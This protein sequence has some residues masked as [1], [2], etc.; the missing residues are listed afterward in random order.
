MTR[1]GVA[2]MIGLLL[3]VAPAP[4]Q[5]PPADDKGTYLG[6]LFSPVSEALYDQLP[7]VPRNQGV[8]VTHVLPDSPAAKA[9]L[10]RHDILLRYND[11]AITDCEH[12]A[13][14]IQADKP[15]RKVKLLLLREG[16]EKTLEVTLGLGPVLQIAQES[17]ATPRTSPDLPK[18][19]AKLGGPPSV[20]VAA[21]PLEHGKMKV[22]VEYYHEG[23]GRL[24]TVTCEGAA[25]EID[26]EIQKRLPE[27]EFNLAKVAL[28]RIRDLNSQKT[29][30]KRS[31]AKP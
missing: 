29:P 15:D 10:H 25:S 23:T 24:R 8:L 16:R 1:A 26:S 6:V 4:G 12:F 17:P 9:E 5:A 13:R 7:Q 21:T 18:G 30:E 28:Q 2:V 20:S 11:V 19:V 3:A 27:R 14:L 31:P 22:I